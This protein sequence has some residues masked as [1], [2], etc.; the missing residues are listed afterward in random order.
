MGSTDNVKKYEVIQELW[1]L[2]ENMLGRSYV[3]MYAYTHRHLKGV[4]VHTEIEA[5]H[6]EEFTTVSKFQLTWRTLGEV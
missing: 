1:N 6:I 2:C 4:S 3:C 5:T